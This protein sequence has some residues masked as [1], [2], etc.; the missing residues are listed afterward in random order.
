[1]PKAVSAALG[2]KG[3]KVS[4]Q[5]ISSLKAKMKNGK[6]V[7][8]GRRGRVAAAS[9]GSI[10]VDSLLAAKQLVAKV[11]SVEDAKQALNVLAQLQS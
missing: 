10:S 5:L 2:E 11:G 1:M 7:R 9:N 8:R 6:K 4:S 3:I